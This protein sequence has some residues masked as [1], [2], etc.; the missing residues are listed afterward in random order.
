[1]RIE[2]KK[3]HLELIRLK[4]ASLQS[5]QAELQATL[6]V[7]AEE[8]GIAPEDS[9]NWTFDGKGFEKPGGEKNE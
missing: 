5:A 2:L 9:K 8:L 3:S 6:G 1:M 4:G 7:I